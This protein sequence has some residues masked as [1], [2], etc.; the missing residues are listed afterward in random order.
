MSRSRRGT[1]VPVEESSTAGYSAAKDRDHCLLDWLEKHAGLGGW[2]GAFGAIVAIFVTWG[3]ARAEYLRTRRLEASRL[4]AEIGL[5]E[6]ITTEFQPIVLRYLQLVDANDRE[7][8]DYRGK[9]T[10]DPRWLRL[11]DLNWLPVTQW[12]SVEAYDRFKQYFA[13][14]NRLLETPMGEEATMRTRRE[15]FEGTFEALQRALEVA[16]R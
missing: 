5:F 12:P 7:A 13:A 9:Q 14:A 16:R 15:A 1:H 8:I 3:L 4:N 10:N 11:V 2:V 6:R